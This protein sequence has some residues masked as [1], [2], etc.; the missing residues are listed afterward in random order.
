VSVCVCVLVCD[1]ERVCVGERVCV[2]IHFV[3][4]HLSQGV[5]EGV[6]VRERHAHT[7]YTYVCVCVREANKMQRLIP[8]LCTC[9]G[10]CV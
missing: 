8:L 9:L 7:E 1:E 4:A 2:C 6:C 5:C 3:A 10:V